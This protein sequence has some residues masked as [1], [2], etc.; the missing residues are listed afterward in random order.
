MLNWPRLGAKNIVKVRNL[1][2]EA[3]SVH[4]NIVIFGLNLRN[5]FSALI[6]LICFNIADI[7]LR[8]TEA[9]KMVVGLA[10][11]PRKESFSKKL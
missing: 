11:I 8:M 5:P 2:I 4:I 6:A 7:K 1:L 10:S 3:K 9:V